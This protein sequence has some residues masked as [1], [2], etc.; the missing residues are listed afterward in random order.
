MNQLKIKVRII[1]KN[2][3]NKNIKSN[4]NHKNN[5]KIKITVFLELKKDMKC[6]IN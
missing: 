5:K 1:N 3:N 6:S 2:K 4:K